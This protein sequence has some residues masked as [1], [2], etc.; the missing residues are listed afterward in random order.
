VKDDGA[1]TG[2]IAATQGRIEGFNASAPPAKSQ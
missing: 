1:W 2:D